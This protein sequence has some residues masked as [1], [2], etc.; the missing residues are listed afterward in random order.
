MTRT[1]QLSVLI[2]R[3]TGGRWMDLSRWVIP[4]VDAASERQR[5]G[6]LAAALCAVTGLYDL[7]I[8][9][10]LH[11]HV[12][13]QLIL[14]A[15]VAALALT[16]GLMPWKRLPDR[17]LW[18][19]VLL[20]VALISLV[21][22]AEMGELAHFAPIYG[23]LFGY[24]GLVFKPGR[25]VS[26]TVV[27]LIGLAVAVLAG[28]QHEHVAE[29]AGAIVI[30]SLT[31]ELVAAAV[32]VHRAH[33]ADLQR[34]H[35]GLASLLVADGQSQAA[36]LIS[37]LAAEL[38]HGDGVSVMLRERAGSSM[39]V[40]RGGC[41]LG[42]DFTKIRIDI[43]AEQSGTGVAA[44]TGQPLFVP[45][46]MNSPLIAKRFA[47]VLSATSVLYLPVIGSREVL[48]VLVVWWSTPVT[49]LDAF[50][51]Q[52]VQL[53]SIQ[54]GP[55]LERARQVEDLDRATLTDPLTGIGNRRAFEHRLQNLSDDEGLIIC[56][57]DQFKTLNDTQGH[58]AGDRVLR[59]FATA[60]ASVVRDSDLVAR[61][62]GDEFVLM[63]RGSQSVVD[64]VL[65][66][67]KLSW[68]RPEGVGFS[69]GSAVRNPGEDGWQ[70]SERADKDLY[71]AKRQSQPAGP[72]LS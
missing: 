48:G 50:A 41:G 39:L 33:R 19:P 20:G 67:L 24:T 70:L 12:E 14:I 66:R 69:A 35:S 62:G 72:K 3:V 58:A 71:A 53:L 11:H 23:L 65:L 51:E 55:V 47:E 28:N 6:R 68:P 44:R 17:S 5:D 1:V 34:L 26:L 61:I 52:V 10:R 45:D 37:G 60:A 38:L 29:L 42:A 40:G 56:D 49:V 36:E 32:S 8:L 27:A 30:S 15:V 31:G 16:L 18:L 57:L 21:Y 59:A 43:D 13:G 64:A 46:A 63:M 9:I 25:T 7:I 22:G 4:H 54:A 2:R